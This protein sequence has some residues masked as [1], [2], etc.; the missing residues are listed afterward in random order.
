[1][2]TELF[3]YLFAT[4]PTFE[5]AAKAGM[6]ITLDVKVYRADRDVWEDYGEHVTAPSKLKAL[7][8]HNWP[9]KTVIRTTYR[10]QEIERATY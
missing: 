4:C 5:A 2:I 8:L 7:L 9:D 1:M 6:K 10:G 3:S